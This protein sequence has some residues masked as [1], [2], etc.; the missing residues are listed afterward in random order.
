MNSTKVSEWAKI[1]DTLA[2]VFIAVCFGLVL[3]HL[4]TTLTKVDTTLASVNAQVVAVGNTQRQVNK[5]LVNVK[6]LVQHADIAAKKESGYLD[7]WN[8]QFTT[9][10]GS[11]ND[12]I[13]SLNAN[14]KELTDHVVYTLDATTATVRGIQPLE[15]QLTATVAS[16]QKATDDLD[17]FIKA[18]EL[19]ETIVNVKT[20]TAQAAQVMTHLNGTTA[21]V[22]HAVHT[23]VYPSWEKKL[24]GYTID[25][26]HVIGAYLF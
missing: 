17:A 23:Y 25:V 4:N 15:K 2:F 3:L 12:T 13:V 11:V 19:H 22:Q 6:D 24:Y 1:V 9:T 14:Q 26:G 5:L 18:P 21:D 10:I 8:K 20:G 7:Q 16:G